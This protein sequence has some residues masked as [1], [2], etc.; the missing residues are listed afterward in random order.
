MPSLIEEVQILNSTQNFSALC[1]I[2]LTGL[3]NFQTLF[4]GISS[5]KNEINQKVKQKYYYNTEIK[6]LGLYM[7]FHVEIFVFLIQNFFLVQ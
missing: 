3:Q 1:V 6:H 2:N 4:M 5:I 7:L